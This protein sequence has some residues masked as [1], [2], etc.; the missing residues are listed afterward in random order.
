MT[1]QAMKARLRYSSLRENYCA[2]IL[3]PPSLRL[4]IAKARLS[5][6]LVWASVVWNAA[7]LS[8]SRNVLD[9]IETTVGRTLRLKTAIMPVTTVRAV[10][11]GNIV[12]SV[13]SRLAEMAQCLHADNVPLQALDLGERGYDPTFG[14]DV[15][16]NLLQFGG[17]PCLVDAGKTRRWSDRSRAS[18]I[19]SGWPAKFRR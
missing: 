10:E 5:D 17:Q 3:M 13:D 14:G 16:G 6:C 18:H 8:L 9:C 12:V 1:R 2:L 19:Y 15:V 7:A 11:S 4:R